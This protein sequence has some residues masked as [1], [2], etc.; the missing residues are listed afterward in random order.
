MDVVVEG[1]EVVEAIEEIKGNLSEWD[2]KEGQQSQTKQNMKAEA[3]RQ[4]KSWS[5]LI[6]NLTTALLI[7]ISKST[8][9]LTST[10]FDTTPCWTCYANTQSMTWIICLFW[11]HKY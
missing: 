10:T 5:A 11:D 2:S 7:Y 8:G 4:S 1:N 9:K 3:Q 6:T